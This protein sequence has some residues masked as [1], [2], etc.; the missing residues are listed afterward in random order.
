[1]SW[2]TALQQL[3]KTGVV[4]FGIHQMNEKTGTPKWRRHRGGA[5][6]RFNTVRS[7]LFSPDK[8]ARA[9]CLGKSSYARD[10]YSSV[11]TSVVP[12]VAIWLQGEEWAFLTRAGATEPEVTLVRASALQDLKSGT[13]GQLLA[14]LALIFGEGAELHG[15]RHLVS[16][17]IQT[18]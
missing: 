7:A 3:D 14:D 12:Y 17:A 13:H 1:M 18:P 9:A 6:F 15:V 4:E 5:N 11:A 16:G 10:R 8:G 2:T